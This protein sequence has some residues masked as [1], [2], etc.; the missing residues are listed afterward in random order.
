MADLDEDSPSLPHPDPTDTDLSDELQDFRFLSHLSQSTTI[1]R[2]GEKDFE[3]HGTQSQTST[4]DASRHAMQNALSVPR[5]HNPKSVIV[6]HYYPDDGSTIIDH[7]KGQN[8]R[9]IGKG[10]AMGRLSL[11]PEEALYMV[12]R[13]SMDLRWGSEELEDIPMSLQ[14]AYVYLLGDRGLTLE[15]YMVFAGLKRLG[16]VVQRAKEWYP[17]DY[18]KGYVAP[19]QLERLGLFAQLYRYLFEARA[20]EG[21]PR[22]PLVA[23]GLYR[24]YASIYRLLTVIPAHDPALPTDRESQRSSPSM[25]HPTSPTHPRIRCSFHVWKPTSGF[26][27][28]TP[29]PPDF[30]IA[31]INA[32]EETFP[33]F[34][35]LDDLLQTMPYSPPPAGTE[36]QVYKR[37][38]HGYRNVLL[39]IVDQG[40][41]SYMRVADAGFGNEKLYERSGRGGRGKRGGMR[42]GRGRGRGRGH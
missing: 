32:R 40:V 5:T 12:E 39:A 7:P 28:A 35:Q 25:G 31:V 11:L 18:D 33:V 27:K 34:E 13:G 20:P 14:A 17:E 29:P 6:G 1:P 15:R 36:G 42:G 22:G 2:R 37:L 41:V 19:R 16:Y 23:P 10:D 4:L 26:K 3:H 8:L 9:T 21:P 30:R 38:K 24:S